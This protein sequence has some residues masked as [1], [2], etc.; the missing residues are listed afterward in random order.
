M[1]SIGRLVSYRTLFQAE[2]F[3][4]DHWL[5][6]S[7]TENSV[8]RQAAKI[9]LACQQALH[10]IWRAKQTARKRASERRS[11]PI[12]VSFRERLSR[13]F[14]RL[15][16]TGELAHRLKSNQQTWFQLMKREFPFANGLNNLFSN[17]HNEINTRSNDIHNILKLISFVSYCRLVVVCRDLFFKSESCLKTIHPFVWINPGGYQPRS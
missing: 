15:P 11:T 3:N 2:V 4:F 16:R 10:F 6:D 12:R 17:C 14:S 13:E 1:V 7:P 8:L 9:E 5:I